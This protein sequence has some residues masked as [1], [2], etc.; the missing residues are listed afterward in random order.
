M[1]IH[2]TTKPK[3]SHI[4]HIKCKASHPSNNVSVRLYTI[5]SD[6]VQQM[7]TT[8]SNIIFTRPLIHNKSHAIFFVLS[9]QSW[10]TLKLNDSHWPTKGQV[11]EPAHAERQ[12]PE[13]K[14]ERQRPWGPH[15]FHRPRHESHDSGNWVMAEQIGICSAEFFPNFLGF[16]V[17]KQTQFDSYGGVFITAK[18]ELEM[19]DIQKLKD[20]E[21]ISST[22]KVPKQESNHCNRLQAP[23]RFNNSYSMSMSDWKG[24]PKELC[25]SLVVILTVQTL[26]GLL[27][28]YKATSS[29][30]YFLNIVNNNLT[31]MVDFPN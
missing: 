14:E 27:S 17:H 8:L 10:L 24:K 28:A 4:K 9:Q 2:L 11:E 19:H 6:T 1:E 16:N 31:P 23:K 3:P 22:L 13:Q 21:M 12:L 20:T 30:I 15:W 29:H 7:S 26:R 18:H 5:P 25:W